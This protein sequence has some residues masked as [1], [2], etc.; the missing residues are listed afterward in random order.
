MAC[1]VGV[2]PAGGVVWSDDVVPISVVICIFTQR[3]IKTRNFMLLCTNPATI[4]TQICQCVVCGTVL[5]CGLWYGPV[6]CYVR[7]VVRSC[8]VVCA[9]CGT[10]LSCGLW[11]G[12]VVGSVRTV[13]RSCRVLCADCGP[14]RYT[15]DFRV[16]MNTKL[17]ATT[18]VSVGDRLSCVRSVSCQTPQ[19]TCVQML[20]ARSQSIVE[21]WNCLISDAE[22]SCH[23]HLATRQ[24]S[25]RT[26]CNQYFIYRHELFVTVK[27][28]LVLT[29]ITWRY[30]RV[31][32]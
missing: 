24:P 12:P 22:V 6:V 30:D 4:Q 10:V 7:T 26:H 16:K 14:V 11:Y 18:T 2:A 23:L 13:V 28:Q 27:I 15:P 20:D 9:V 5:S 19:R 31:A 3:R 21:Q 25:T 32:V 29:H 17:S 8:R 1:F